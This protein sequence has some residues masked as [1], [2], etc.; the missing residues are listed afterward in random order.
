MI[1]DPRQ[2][3]RT[4]WIQR[5]ILFAALVLIF[6]TGWL[7][8]IDPTYGQRADKT[9]L[10]RKTLYPGRGL[11]FDRTG[12]LMVHN[13]PVYD[14]KVIYNQVPKGMD[15]ALLCRL[16]EI[17]KASFLERMNKDWKSLRYSIHSFPTRRSSDHRKSVV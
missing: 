11:I 1:Q 14:L 6:Q 15:T 4:L 12:Q 9:T 10:V 5:V 13:I 16:L 3:G 17:D 2:T 7:Q 8:L